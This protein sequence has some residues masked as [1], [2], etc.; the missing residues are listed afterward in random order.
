MQQ[1]VSC[2]AASM[3]I[4]CK[5]NNNFVILSPSQQLSERVCFESMGYRGRLGVGT[6]MLDGEIEMMKAG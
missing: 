3:L 5:I 6:W 4:L 2:F 1:V